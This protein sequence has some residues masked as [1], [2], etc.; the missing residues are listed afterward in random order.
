[1]AF[2]QNTRN[3]VLLYYLTEMEAAQN[4]RL[5]DKA[6]TV[7]ELQN[8]LAQMENQ[9]LAAAGNVIESEKLL[10]NHLN[11]SSME[12][13]RDVF[14]E[15]EKQLASFDEALKSADQN[16]PFIQELKKESS[17]IS[18]PVSMTDQGLGKLMDIWSKLNK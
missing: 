16:N 15:V 11:K 2:I 9:L 8:Q 1:V 5:N 14:A 4:Q 12:N 18:S 3:R 17:A 7:K 13:V 6:A 10:H